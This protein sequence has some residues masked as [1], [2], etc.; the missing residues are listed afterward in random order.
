MSQVQR[1]RAATVSGRNSSGQAEW[2][3]VFILFRNEGPAR[4]CS[5]RHGEEPAK[6]RMATFLRGGV[7][8]S[9]GGRQG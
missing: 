5:Q 3:L 4:S 1:A 2:E 6:I 9:I 8:L 7:D